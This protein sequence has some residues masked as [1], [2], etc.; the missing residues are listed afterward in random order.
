MFKVK[1]ML[2][3]IALVAVVGV[4]GLL[5]SNQEG[6]TGGAVA[7]TIACYEDSDCDDRIGATEDL[8]KNPGTE[9]SLC[10]NKPIV[11]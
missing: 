5:M 2:L 9:Y 11:N 1:S 10:V 3:V 8:C 6:I 7:N 4:V